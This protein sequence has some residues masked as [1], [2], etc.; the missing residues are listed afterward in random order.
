MGLEGADV[1]A[2]F[3]VEKTD[4]AIGEA[5]GEVV[6][7]EGE[8]A[9]ELGVRV[10]VGGRGLVIVQGGIGVSACG[11]IPGRSMPVD[12]LILPRGA[13]PMAATPDAS[14]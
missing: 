6:V 14:R 13:Q 11:E 10:D 2:R 12:E 4:G 9:A 1:G 3:E 5:T 7:G 8:A